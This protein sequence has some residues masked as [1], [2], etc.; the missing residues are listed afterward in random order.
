[1]KLAS[2]VS[3]T[4]FRRVNELTPTGSM[5]QAN[6]PSPTGSQPI[7]TAPGQQVQQDPQAQAKMMAQQALDRNNRKKQIQDQI[8]ATQKQLQDL[9][10]QL[11]TIK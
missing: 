4:E 2:I 9:Q 10:K 6:I 8:T 3:E 1:M 5:T 7:T 11:A